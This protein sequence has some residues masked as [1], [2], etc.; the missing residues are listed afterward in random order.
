MVRIGLLPFLRLVVFWILGILLYRYTAEINSVI[1]IILGLFSGV[2]LL[3]C[4]FNFIWKKPSEAVYKVCVVGVLF[5]SLSWL[6]TKA[7]SAE[8]AANH[9]EKVGGDYVIIELSQQP[10][11]K[12]K[13]LKAEGRVIRVLDTTSGVYASGRLLIYFLDSIDSLS[14]GDHILCKKSL[15]NEVGPP[16]NPGQFNL[17]QY[18]QHL[19]IGHQAFIRKGGFVIIKRSD[20]QE[21]ISRCK[22]YLFSTLSFLQGDS[23]SIAEALILGDKSNL[24]SEI[25]TAFSDTGA[26][27]ILAVSGLHVGIIYLIVQQLLLLIF[28]KKRWQ[29]LRLTLVLCALWFYAVITGLSP[30]VQ[31]ASFMFS[32]IALGSFIK[33]PNSILN[34]VL[35]SAFVLLLIHPMMLFR[36]GFQLSYAAVLGI[37]IFHPYIDRWIPSEN[38]IIRSIWSLTAVSVAAQIGTF[39]ITLYY[40]NQFPIIFALTNLIAIPGAFLIVAGGLLLQLLVPLGG[41]LLTSYQWLMQSVIDALVGGIHALN[42]LPFVSWKHLIIE[43]WDVGLLFVA[44]FIATHGL[45]N[46]HKKMVWLTLSLLILQQGI[47][48]VQRAYTQPKAQMVVFDTPRATTLGF[49]AMNTGFAFSKDSLGPN[50]DFMIN[51]FFKDRPYRSVLLNDSMYRPIAPLAVHAHLIQ[52]EKTRV[53]IDVVDS[54]LTHYFQYFILSKAA[55]WKEMNHLPAEKC[56]FDASVKPEW[57]LKKYPKFAD[58]HFVQ[59]DG[60]YVINFQ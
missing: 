2:L 32:M 30:S 18:L 57:V 26:M 33:R 35:V 27:H 34:N 52:F 39:P 11:Q 20:G 47:H 46:R 44:I 12:K 54:T 29:G 22:Q 9:F 37:I 31:R 42:G 7:S 17:R 50:V 23:R 25:K 58:S 5:T 55:T 13:S 14:L 59:R 8:N 49:K 60:A 38:R 10:V 19:G 45:I 15:I 51:G 21:W 6:N 53:A 28:G 3:L 24:R 41:T 43:G 40:F 56:V 4:S 48:W 1:P 36:V 16:T